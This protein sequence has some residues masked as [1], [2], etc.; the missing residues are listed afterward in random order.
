MNYQW[1]D[2]YITILP[3]FLMII[4]SLLSIYFANC[5]CIL[6]CIEGISSNSLVSNIID[7]DALSVVA[8][9]FISL[10]IGYFLNGASS[11]I[12]HRMYDRGKWIFPSIKGQKSDKETNKKANVDLRKR[13]HRAMTILPPNPKIEEY[14]VRYAQARNMLFM[15]VICFFISLICSILAICLLSGC[16]CIGIS[17]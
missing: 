15:H 6:Q 3:G 13:M 1:K 5:N 10:A 7:N 14:Y 4:Y 8:V 16:Y 12:E 2:V 17:E 9:S 11:L